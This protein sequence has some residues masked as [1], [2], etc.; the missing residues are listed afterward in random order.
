MIR[1]VLLAI[2]LSSSALAARPGP[3]PPTSD[4]A[5]MW[6]EMATLR[7]QVVAHELASQ[8]QLTPHQKGLLRPLAEEASQLRR[9]EQDARRA[10]APE[11]K[12]LLERYLEEL[13]DHGVPDEQTKRSIG[14]LVDSHRPSPQE[15]GERQEFRRDVRDELRDILT[16]RQ[17]D[18]LQD[19]RPLLDMAESESDDDRPRGRGKGPGVAGRRLQHAVRIVRDVLLSEEMLPHL[20]TPR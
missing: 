13:R 14:L 7:R 12:R 5:P 17:M 2:L 1:P 3:P 8:L 4:E 20:G 16:V 19:F 15:R 18:V 9:T 11:L 10:D 6:G